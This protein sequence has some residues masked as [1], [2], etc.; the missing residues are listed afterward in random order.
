MQAEFPG[1]RADFSQ[2]P[3]PAL[4]NALADGNDFLSVSIVLYQSSSEEFAATLRALAKAVSRVSGWLP[5]R[6][7]LINNDPAAT[8]QGSDLFSCADGMQVDYLCGHGN[9]GFGAGHNLVLEKIGG[10]HLILNPDAE[11]AEDALENAL[12]FMKRHPDCGLLSPFATWEDG[13]RQYL[14]KRYPTILDLL[15]RGFAPAFVKRLFKN[16]LDYYEMYGVTEEKMVWDPPIIS[17]CF[18]LF[19]CDVLQRL[20]GFDPAYFLYFEDFDLSLRA[21]KITRLAYVPS[22]RIVHHGGHASRKGF[23]HI[24]MFGRSALRFFRTHGWRLA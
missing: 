24:A 18:M 12:A 3:V 7:F 4:G 20:G 11:L 15:L 13:R 5:V 6:L 16:R 23:R 21:A 14:C 2:Q 1:I 22:V 9:V 10:F 17:G 19:R 8:E